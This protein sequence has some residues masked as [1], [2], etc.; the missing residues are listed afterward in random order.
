MSFIRVF[1]QLLETIGTF[2]PIF[3]VMF[4]L[5]SSLFNNSLVKGL[6]Y[7]TGLFIIWLFWQLLLFSIKPDGSAVPNSFI[8]SIS[9]LNFLNL[10]SVTTD[11]IMY[12]LSPI[13]VWFTN[14][15]I[16]FTMIYSSVR[17]PGPNASFIGLIIA[18][19]LC[20]IYSI[21]YQKN[22]TDVKSPNKNLFPL[23]YFCLSAVGVIFGIL[24]FY[25]SNIN[26]DKLLFSDI[27]Y[28]NSQLCNL[29]KNKNFTCQFYKDGIP[30]KN[31]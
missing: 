1:K 30:I 2:W 14:L 31:Q 15:Y 19:T 3:S 25:L 17:K 29:D 9:S 7:F 24:W 22:S 27:L 13:T 20:N 12:I 10:T 16:F 18:G 11:S 6:F 8:F 21:F 28:Q 4:L 23:I 26:P 5:I